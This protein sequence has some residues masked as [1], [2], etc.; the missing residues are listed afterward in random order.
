MHLAYGML[1]TGQPFDERHAIGAVPT[2][3]HDQRDPDHCKTWGGG[4]LCSRASSGI[5]TPPRG[6]G[7]QGLTKGGDCLLS[8]LVTKHGICR[9][10]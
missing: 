4:R 9:S 8:G 1:N 10:S 7:P 5:V 2:H 3:P 6:H